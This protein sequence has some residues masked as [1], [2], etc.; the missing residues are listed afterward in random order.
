MIEQ[1]DRLKKVAEEKLAGCEAKGDNANAAKLR[2]LLLL[3]D[4]YN[5][6]VEEV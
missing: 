5:T 4:D 2:E 3:I 6:L 1:M